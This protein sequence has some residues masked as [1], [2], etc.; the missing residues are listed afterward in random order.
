LEHFL[1]KDYEA[2]KGND[3]GEE[4]WEPFEKPGMK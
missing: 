1:P 3:S 2:V 4:N